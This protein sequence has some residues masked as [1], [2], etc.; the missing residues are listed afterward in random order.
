M[1]RQRV[2]PWGNLT[3]YLNTKIADGKN[4]SII[5]KETNA[6]VIVTDHHLVD[7]TKYPYDV[8][9]VVNPQREN[10]T[11]SRNLSGTHVIYYLLLY[12][13]YKLYDN[14]IPTAKLNMFYYYLTYVGLTIISDF[15]RL[16]DYVNRKIVIKALGIINNDKIKHNAFWN[17][18]KSKVKSSYYIN[19]TTLSFELI[20]LINSTNRVDFP[21][22]GYELLTVDDYEYGLHLYE[23]IVK[24]NDR[25]KDL[26]NK[27]IN[28]KHVTKYEDSVIHISV[29]KDV[30]DVQGIL[31]SRMLSDFNFM[32]AIVFT[33]SSDGT[34][35]AGSGRM[36]DRDGNNLRDILSNINDKS[37]LIIEYGGH[38]GAAGLKIK[39]RPKEFFKLLQEEVKHTTLK[40]DDSLYVDDIIYS[41]RKLI[42]TVYDIRN[43]G[44]YGSSYAKP[45]FVSDVAI[46][47]YRVYDKKQNV[48]LSAM[49][50]LSDKSNHAVNMFY[51][52]PMGD[53][54]EFLNTLKNT[55]HLR[56]VYSI[57]INNYM[58]NNKI[59][60]DAIKVFLK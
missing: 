44:P 2:E 19:E 38:S 31:A 37:D 4:L 36:T 57:S 58:D 56:I 11:I 40:R 52:I 5:K 50:K 60:L 59:S 48:Y 20:P 12:T 43:G 10:G 55:K 34:T 45:T 49:V 35:L 33:V 30:K 3:N 26:Q 29:S 27:G 24:I 54:D 8:D 32:L 23:N 1:D 51:S 6:D 13:A 21:I 42:T 14:R 53:K 25:R 41:N 7:A 18:V 15:M 39:N 16:N 46:D 22:K 17:V 9:A 28:S 47:S